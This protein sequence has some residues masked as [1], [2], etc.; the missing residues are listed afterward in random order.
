MAEPPVLDLVEAQIVELHLSLCLVD[1][2]N[3][4]FNQLWRIS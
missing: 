4:S 3:S 2:G 1:E